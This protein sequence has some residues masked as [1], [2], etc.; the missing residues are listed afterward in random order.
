MHKCRLAGGNR[1]FSAVPHCTI[2]TG[3]L[4]AAAAFEL[5][6]SMELANTPRTL[7]ALS[8]L[9]AVAITVAV[10]TPLLEMAARIIV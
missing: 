7:R 8:V 4:F 5:E 9:A 10:A 6:A 1:G 3:R 2:L